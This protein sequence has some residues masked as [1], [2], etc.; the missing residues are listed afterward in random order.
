MADAGRLV[1]GAWMPAV[2]ANGYPIF[3]AYIRVYTN[4][5]STL[6]TIYADQA[7]TVPLPN[8]LDADSSGQFPPIWQDSALFFSMEFGSTST[9]P[10]GTV[11]DLQPSTNIGGASDKLDRDG[12]NPAP[13]LLTNIGAAPSS[14]TTFDDTID[15][16]KRLVTEK[17]LDIVNAKDGFNFELLRPFNAKASLEA[18]FA[19]R[20][21]D[22]G[23]VT[24]PSGIIHLSSLKIPAGVRVIGAGTR[25]GE[26]KTSRNYARLGTVIYLDPAGTITLENMASLENVTIL[27]PNLRY[28]TVTNGVPDCTEAQNMGTAPYTTG[29]FAGQLAGVAQFSGVAITNNGDDTRVKDC[30]VIGFNTAYRS[31]TYA[32]PVPGLAPG[33]SRPHVDGLWFDCTN[34]IDVYD[35][36]DVAQISHNEGYAFF[37]AHCG[38]SWA[39]ILRSGIAYY[40]HDHVD[41]AQLGFNFDIGHNIG[42][43]FKNVFGIQVVSCTS[44]G[45][46]TNDI[47]TTSRGLVTEGTINGLWLN[48]VQGDAHYSNFEFNHTAGVV[49]AG[50]IQSG[51]STGP[52]YI[53]GPGSQGAIGTLGI[54]ASIGDNILI[55]TGV[56]QWGIGQI[57]GYYMQPNGV[58]N[59]LLHFE[60]PAD[61]KK[62]QRGA[63]IL[64]S[65]DVTN[66]PMGPSYRTMRAGSH[67]SNRINMSGADATGSGQPYAGY[68]GLWASGEDANVGLDLIAKGTGAESQVRLQRGAVGARELMGRIQAPVGSSAASFLINLTAGQVEFAAEGPSAN[69]SAVVS[70]KGL[71]KAVLNG[72]SYF[73]NGSAA[74]NPL[75]RYDI[76]FEYASDTALRIKMMGSDGQIRFATLT[77]A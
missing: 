19:D 52:G 42:Y 4:R 5:T 65:W 7:L 75:N 16:E 20:V 41:G 39:S 37:N 68:V 77:L 60:T 1:N 48:N 62:F 66:D 76:T 54:A 59:S 12:A 47:A 67:L 29:P 10:I 38:F 74:N 8:P 18:L 49:G 36:W 17:L 43:K 61:S 35:C 30:L 58:G 34:G 73:V 40:F 23:P 46:S 26:E 69:Y 51:I 32:V 15:V 3:D 44:D 25:P 9:G 63:A 31:P 6:A 28:V 33:P 14:V 57:L 21:E 11:D 27:N 2:D 70:P 22:G 64:D 55:K 72:P 56:G 45:A 71:G 13:D 24:L 50:V 53:F